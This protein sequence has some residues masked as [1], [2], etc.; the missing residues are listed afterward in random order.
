MANRRAVMICA[1]SCAAILAA[2]GCQS[3]SATQAWQRVQTLTETQ[4]AQA[5]KAQAARN[6]LFGRLTVRLQEE[7]SAAGPTA[8]ISVCRLEAP[9]FAKAVAKEHGV[10][11]GRTSWRLR[12]Q[13]NLPPAWANELVA[14]RI[15]EPAYL[16]GP[17]GQLGALLPIRLAKNCETC[18]GPSGQIGPEIRQVLAEHYPADQA[19]GFVEGELR[20]W[21]WVEVPR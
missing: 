2:A 10:A 16:V 9:Q 4:Q 21:F 3:G 15:A 7:L 6:D 14:E 18:H 20:G 11:I 13:N 8:A 5:S 1:G 17:D 19:T 12:N